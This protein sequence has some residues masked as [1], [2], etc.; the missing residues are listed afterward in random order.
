[1]ISLLFVGDGERD[2]AT[3]PH[4]VMRILGAEVEPVTRNRAHLHQAGKGYQKKVRFALLQAL[5]A[6]AAGLIAVVDRDK[7]QHGE[8]LKQLRAA[9]EKVRME[10]PPFP[11]AFGE[12]SPHGEAWLLD[13]PAAIRDALGLDVDAEIVAIS[14]T[15]D[16]KSVLNDLIG[17][18]NREGTEI[19]AVLTGIARLVDPERCF[20]ASHTGFRDFVEDVRTEIGPLVTGQLA[21]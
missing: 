6:G 19:L 9:R 7:S 11:M 15:R 21:G 3:V 2:A 16:P 12:A 4:L 14:R 10:K 13:D 18:S 8:K 5:D 1:M 20:H 17:R